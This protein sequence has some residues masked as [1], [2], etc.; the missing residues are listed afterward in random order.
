MSL[1]FDALKQHREPVTA[2][3]SASLGSVLP[4]TEQPGRSRIPAKKNPIWLAVILLVAL[5]A[6]FALHQF[7]GPAYPASGSPKDVMQHPSPQRP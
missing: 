3:L 2:P 1:V 4:D 7:S 5:A 6:G